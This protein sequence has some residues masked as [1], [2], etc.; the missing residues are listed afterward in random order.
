MSKGYPTPF[1][2][3]K[4][5][6]G[7]NFSLYS[8]HASAV[9]L[10]FFE[11]NNPSPVQKVEVVN[12]TGDVWHVLIHNL[13][14]HLKYAYKISGI[15]GRSKAFYHSDKFLLDPYAKAVDTVNYWGEEKSRT[16]YKPLGIIDSPK[17]FDWE[18]VKP[19]KLLLKDLI[20]YEMHVRGFTQ[21]SSSGVKNKG[22]FL[23][24]IEKIPHLVDL[25]INAVELLPVTEFNE[26]E[27]RLRH[28]STHK[29]MYNYWGYS[30]VSFFSLMNRYATP[31]A[32]LGEVIIEF[33]TMVRELHRQGIEVILDVVFNHTAEGNERGPVISYKGIDP[34]IYYHIDQ[35]NHYSN[36]T[37]CGNTLNGNHPAS[38]ELIR[39]CLR[40][41]VSEMLIDGF[42]FDLAS[43][44]TRGEGGEPLIPSP[45]FQAISQDPVL[46]S[47]KLI[48][49]PWDAQGLYQLG[50]FCSEESRWSEWNDQYRKCVRR[51]IK[52]TPYEKKVFATRICGSQD[53][54]GNRSPLSSINYATC[55][56][57]FSLYDLV[58]YN[59]KHNLENGE[60]DRDG[61]PDNES[62]NCGFEG[63]TTD[64]QILSLRE[65]QIRNFHLALML[66]QGV[67]M[68]LMGDE[69]KHTKNGNNNPWGQDNDLNWFLWN[70]L[71]DNRG[72][73]R[74]YKGLIHFRKKNPMLKNDKFFSPSE[75]E[76][77]GHEPFEPNWDLAN[78]FLAFTIKE[79]KGDQSLYAA[80]NTSNQT[81]QVILPPPI[82][83][84]EWRMIVNTANDPPLDFNEEESTSALNSD[85]VEMVSYSAILLKT[86]LPSS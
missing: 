69:Y 73:F 60:D 54:Y 44:L 14:S 6:H 34:T 29:K 2:V 18:G 49:E 72:F 55:H 32:S 39:D 50:S 46:S 19:P 57:G 11:D 80:F 52:G 37:G 21:H 82:S 59:V 68:L 1:G 78:L 65:R 4:R 83:S 64:S 15:Y 16:V 62:W 27:N 22:T 56:D 9:S 53:L 17:E 76:W 48:A 40:Y 43:A 7:A 20:I 63:L 30:P 47:T 79:A 85:T 13:P 8:K 28:P 25:G 45:L 24:I 58:S 84:K 31:K 70:Q 23:G 75:I 71:E 5:A 10:Y 41:W 36:F 77:H 51:F 26:M 12:K 35:Q 33:K 81:V 42:R 67:P 61:N 74:F 86:F 66:S 3:T 38:I